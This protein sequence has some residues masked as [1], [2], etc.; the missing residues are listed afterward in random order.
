MIQIGNHM[1]KTD[2]VLMKYKSSLLHAQKLFEEGDL[3]EAAKVYKTLLLAMPESLIVSQNLGSILAE[4]GDLDGAKQVLLE[5]LKRHP[6]SYDLSYNLG[7]VCQRLHEAESAKMHYLHALKIKSNDIP[8]LENLAALVLSLGLRDE[9]KSY[10]NQ[11]LMVDPERAGALFTMSLIMLMEGDWHDGWHLYEYRWD[12]PDFQKLCTGQI[13]NRWQQL[14]DLRNS[15]VLLV[16]E[17]GAGDTIQFCRYALLL[18]NHGARVTLLVHPNLKEIIKTI[19]SFTLP[20]AIEVLGTDELRDEAVYDYWIPMMSAPFALMKDY[21]KVPVVNQYLFAS[22]FDVQEAK[23]RIPDNKLPNIGLVWSGSAMHKNDSNRSAPFE[24]FASIIS[25]NANFHI[26]Q[27]E[28]QN[29]DVTLVNDYIQN[30][31]LI[32]HHSY[33][34]DFSKTAA[35][36]ECMDLVISVDTSI[37]HMAGALGCHTWVA[38]AYS[39]DF[40]WLLDRDD[41]P[42]YPSIHLFRQSSYNDWD[43]LTQT[44]A[45]NLR[46]YIESL[47]S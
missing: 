26:L 42:W 41:S 46:M 1:H 32:S 17:Q 13:S 16:N 28:I 5:S 19:N 11:V 2:H 39:P 12:T 25:E 34:S 14:A 30:G 40:R 35:L 15:S 38:L 47:S 10:L 24:K 7:V 8:T 3:T 45:K 22:P 6:A 21:A 23:A 4:C 31:R 9:A 20:N 37:V 43:N 33:L 44:I 29:R 27:T 18:A 36:I